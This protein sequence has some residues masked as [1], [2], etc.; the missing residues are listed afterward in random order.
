M[1]VQAINDT[2]TLPGF[3]ASITISGDVSE[4]IDAAKS[5]AN[6]AIST[7]DGVLDSL[8]D[9]GGDALS[10]AVAAIERLG[11]FSPGAIEFSYDIPP[12][13][14]SSFRIPDALSLA[15]SELPEFPAD[16]ATELAAD[17]GI[18][19]ATVKKLTDMIKGAKKPASE[20]EIAALATD[21]NLDDAAVERVVRE[22]ESFWGI[23]DVAPELSAPDA[24]SFDFEVQSVTPGDVSTAR[25]DALN[26]EQPEPPSD[27]SA[28]APPSEPQGAD[29]S[30]PAAPDLSLPSP[31]SLASFSEPQL[32]PLVMPA[33]SLP[34]VPT[35]VPPVVGEAPLLPEIAQTT[36]DPSKARYNS[37]LDLTSFRPDLDFARAIGPR[38]TA[39][40]IR[41][42]TT[43]WADDG[44]I[45]PDGVVL[46][47]ATYRTTMSE[48]ANAGE[49]RRIDI[50]KY[51]AQRELLLSEA[52]GKLKQWQQLFAANEIPLQKIAFDVAA[53]YADTYFSL[54]KSLTE[55]YNA[56]VA[57]FSTESAVY[58]ASVESAVAKIERWK[59]QVEAEISKSK[60]ND[61]LAQV[62]GTKVQARLTQAELYE[63][64]VMAVNAQVEAY[65]ARMEAFATEAEVARVKLGVYKGQVDAYIG[66][67]SAYKA[68]FDVYEA[69]VRGT[70][71]AN[72][73]EEIKTKVAM[74]E[75]QAVG[76]DNAAK[77]IKIQ[78]EAEKL[79]L[80]TRK[81]AASYETK[82]LT[83]I[84]ETV[85]AQIAGDIGKQ[86]ILQW[87]ANVQL[88]DVQNDAIATEAQAAAKYYN[89]ASDSA[90]RASEQAFRAMLSAAQAA[91]IAQDAASRSAASVAQ[92][93]YSAVHVNAGLQG[94]G[95][96]SGE[97]SSDVKQNQSV[98]DTLSYS[99]SKQLTL[100]A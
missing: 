51:Y 78:I 9:T 34:D 74:A 63:A 49:Q 29:I 44:Q 95:R 22:A 28:V 48:L 97:E 58:R 62:Y 83:N 81:E 12:Y 1:F 36:F 4:G 37:S 50:D 90:Y 54:L 39:R 99:E 92:G 43:R 59:V 17:L 77:E 45:L 68:K 80:N 73:L 35:Y 20:D 2:V 19:V 41:S 5:V 84:I 8:R 86:K 15:E 96:V 70:S 65:R 42:A 93:A 32:V 14:Q 27:V 100:S 88:E 69:R 21:L 82:K 53:L 60:V 6:G 94:S 10:D 31:P 18:D 25:P 72:Q 71:A 67:L 66:S 24:G 61:Q 7:V 16:L 98:S 40:E 76:A 57:A 52:D 47:Q 64:S 11:E 33:M 38:V 55:L 56:R 75:M 89:T 79:K 91:N 85:K 46:A 13:Q 30:V 87:G 3:P 23:E 26:L